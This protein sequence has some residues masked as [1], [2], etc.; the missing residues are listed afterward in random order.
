[1]NLNRKMKALLIAALA[2]VSG[3]GLLMST[4]ATA[5]ASNLEK[6][7]NRSVTLAVKAKAPPPPPEDLPSPPPPEDPPAPRAPARP[8]APSDRD[9]RSEHGPTHGPDHSEHA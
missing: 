4:P 9:H 3:V 7:S 8:H 1:M 5:Q 2:S 6:P